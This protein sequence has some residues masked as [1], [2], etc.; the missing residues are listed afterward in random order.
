MRT[1]RAL[2]LLPDLSCSLQA[3]ALHHTL[4]TRGCLPHHPVND[5]CC[6]PGT[7]VRHSE[8]LVLPQLLC[9]DRSEGLLLVSCAFS[10]CAFGRRAVDV[11]LYSATGIACSS[12][13]VFKKT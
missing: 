7:L 9:L 2:V 10:F 13:A 1:L 6:F 8:F 11:S 5:L 4:K 3:L 12:D